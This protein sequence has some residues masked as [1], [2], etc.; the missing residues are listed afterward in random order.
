MDESLTNPFRP[1]LSN[2]DDPDEPSC[3]AYKLYSIGAVTLATVLGSLLAGGIVM[4]INYKRLGQGAAAV[5]AVFW[6]LVATVVIIGAGMLIPEDVKIPN[7]A[8]LAPQIIGMYYLAKSLQG[9]AIEAHPGEG[10]SLAS[11]W[12]A[13][14]I[15]I[16]TGIVVLAAL[17]GVIFGVMMLTDPGS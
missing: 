9:P 8:F 15:G 5:H 3:P 17:F 2:V 14:G 7:V 4:A 6:S 12:G 10:G 1:P 11:N 16:L 13:A